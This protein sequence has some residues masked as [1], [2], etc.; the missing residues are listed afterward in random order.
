MNLAKQ[1]F[2]MLNTPSFAVNI[3]PLIITLR[4][5]LRHCVSIRGEGYWNSMEFQQ[6]LS[7]LKINLNLHYQAKGK[8]ALEKRTR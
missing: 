7:F 3:L 4:R 6:F 5:L 8:V 2:E 1:P